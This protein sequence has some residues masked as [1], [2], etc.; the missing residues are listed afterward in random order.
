MDEY[1]LV[2]E[3][4]GYVYMIICKMMYVFKEA[5][6]LAFTNLVKY[7]APYGYSPMKFTPGLWQ[8]NTRKTTFTLCID[9][10]G[11]KYFS[12]DD[13]HH[14]INTVN[15]NYK[16]TTNMTG[17]LYIG[18]NLDWK[19]TASPAYIDLSMKGFVDQA[20]TKFDH[21]MPKKPQH[22]P[23]PPP[24]PVLHQSMARRLPSGLYPPKPNVSST[25]K[26]K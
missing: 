24:L 3:D 25:T 2:I 7:M 4:D 8:H 17:R 16:V 1:D 19:Y 10:F 9:D 15:T 26:V 23:L 21:P 13:A 18:V 22:P 12:K 14:I 20:W 5:G 6:I 11:I